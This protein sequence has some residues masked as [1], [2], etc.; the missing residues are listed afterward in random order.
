MERNEESAADRV[1][2][3]KLSAL[4][5]DPDWEPDLQRGAA[6]LRH[7]RTAK[8]SGKVRLLWAV[9]AA[10]AVSI[11]I[12]ALGATR[13]FVARCV[14][15]CVAETEVV[16]QHLLGGA[17]QLQSSS[18]YIR[19]EL[20]RMAPDFALADQAGNTVR[21]SD[22]RGKVVLV[23]FWATWCAPCKEEIP[24][25][26]KLRQSNQERGFEVVGISTDQGGWDA[27]RPFVNAEGVGYPV[28][29]GNAGLLATFGGNQ[30][31]PLT[32]V[33]DRLGRVAAIHAG[34]CR[35]SEYADDVES[36]LE[37]R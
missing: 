23:N 1:L 8:R 26:V 24:W 10:T 14:S 4:R 30:A 16:R 34:R 22:Y 18:V 9:A 12:V 27:V 3:A 28:V 11:P 37:E 13:S 32:V 29:L 20:R 33:V 2:A 31:I 21:L 5:P 25:F 17:A 15:A 36:L 6:M 19:P 7:K 35:E